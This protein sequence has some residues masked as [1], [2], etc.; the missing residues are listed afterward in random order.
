MFDLVKIL[1]FA[2]LTLNFSSH[3]YAGTLYGSL[4]DVNT[5]EEEMNATIQPQSID[6]IMAR[7]TDPD[8]EEGTESVLSKTASSVV[9]V[10]STTDANMMYGT[11]IFSQNEKGVTVTGNLSHLPPGKHGFHVHENGSC[12]DEGKAA[13]GHFNPD[14]VMHGHLEDHPQNAHA[15]DM[16]NIEVNEQGKANI[17]ILLPEATL[18]EGKYSLSGKALIIHEKEDDF[19]QP[20]GNAGGRIGCGIINPK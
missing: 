2:S 14:N 7:V 19:G 4:K 3:S 18:T 6:E 16:G 11:L 17:D 8:R 9:M 15:G 1:F 20:T 13:G 12:A 5:I 10:S